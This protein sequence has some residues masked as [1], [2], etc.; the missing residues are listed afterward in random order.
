LIQNKTD[1]DKYVAAVCV[2]A[3]KGTK[4]EPAQ[5]ALLIAD[6][7][8]SGDAHAGNWNRQISLLPAERIGEFNAEG[9]N[10]AYGDFG[11]N[12][13][14]SG[15]DFQALAVG[16]RLKING[17]TL[18]LTQFGKECHDRC[19]IYY[20][21]GRCIMPAHGVFARVLAGGVIAPGDCIEL[22]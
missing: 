11:E 2:S 3:R 16:S 12:I 6:H 13:V 10:V 17:V 15:V 5:S 18:E 7:G 4:K 9:A 14:T 8:I 1:S 21:V 20:S 22:L 19:A